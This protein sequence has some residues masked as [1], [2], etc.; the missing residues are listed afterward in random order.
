MRVALDHLRQRRRRAEEVSLADLGRDALDW[1]RRDDEP[2]EREVRQAGELLDHLMAVLSP[3]ERLVITLMEI[4]GHSVKE[5]C[6]LTGS[7]GVAVRVRALRARVKLRQA[8]CR[9]ERKEA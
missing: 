5:V 7:S 4:Q 9:W 3:A 6:A 2:G 8:L 1:L